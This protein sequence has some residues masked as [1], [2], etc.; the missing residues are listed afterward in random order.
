MVEIIAFVSGVSLDVSEIIVFHCRGIV[1][2]ERLT[3]MGRGVLGT[4]EVLHTL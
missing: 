2:C 1:G 4:F 3:K